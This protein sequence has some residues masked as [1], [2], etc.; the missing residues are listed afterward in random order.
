MRWL[1]AM[2]NGEA[3]LYKA[4]WPGL[5][6]FGVCNVLY[7]RIMGAVVV[8]ER[9]MFDNPL[10]AD[11]SDLELAFPALLLLAAGIV[12]GLCVTVVSAGVWQAA[13][14]YEGKWPLWPN[15]AFFLVMLG[16]VF[17]LAES[18]VGINLIAS[19]FAKILGGMPGV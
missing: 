8:Y 14:R 18:V 13:D 15:L 9:N 4:F 1:H 11:K 10:L 19:T 6:I 7:L 16:N 5:V 2:T 3:K 17:A 12:L